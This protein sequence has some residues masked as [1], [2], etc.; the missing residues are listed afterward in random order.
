MIDS[1][2]ATRQVSRSDAVHRLLQLSIESLAPNRP[3]PRISTSRAEELATSQIGPLIDP[4]ASSEERDRRIERLAKGR[5]NSS[6]PVSINRSRRP[7]ERVFS[8]VDWFSAGQRSR[9][10]SAAMPAGPQQA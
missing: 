5:R 9:T 4:D 8:D 7:D 2:A 1:F 10:P 6:A 3:L